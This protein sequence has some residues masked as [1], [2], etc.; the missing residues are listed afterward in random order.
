MLTGSA[1]AGS[2]AASKCDTGWRPGGSG[3]TTPDEI[4]AGVEVDSEGSARSLSFNKAHDVGRF[5]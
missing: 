1:F 5:T 3:T 4:A 2:A